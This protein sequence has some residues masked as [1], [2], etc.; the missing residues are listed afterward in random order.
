MALDHIIDFLDRGEK[1][2]KVYLPVVLQCD[3][4][5]NGKRLTQLADIDLRSVT[6]DVT[7]SDWSF[8]TRIRQ[9]LGERATSSASSTLVMRP[10][11]CSS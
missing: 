7:P 11:F 2:G 10:F 8:F 9:G 3:L 4:S 6:S 1:S 5:E